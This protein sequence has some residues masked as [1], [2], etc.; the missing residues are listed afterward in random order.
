MAG[1]AKG[2]A[3]TSGWTLVQCD[4]RN[5]GSTHQ[6]LANDVSLARDE[7]GSSDLF[8]EFATY[9]TVQG[10]Q[11]KLRMTLATATFDFR[12]WMQQC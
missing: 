6:V 11:F 7:G 5:Q 4:C 9:K 2:M 8:M 1:F 10:C 3:T 12:L